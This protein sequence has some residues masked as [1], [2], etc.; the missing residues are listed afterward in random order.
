M[1]DVENQRDQKEQEN[2]QLQNEM[3]KCYY[4]AASKKELK[5]HNILESGF[6]K[7]SKLMAG[8]FDKTFFTTSDRRSLNEIKLHSKKAKV[9]TNQPAASYSIIDEDG[10]KVLRITNKDQFWSLGNYLVIQID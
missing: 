7:K 4:V 3:N 10:Q 8:D 5:S 2:V 6:L 1:A 9:L